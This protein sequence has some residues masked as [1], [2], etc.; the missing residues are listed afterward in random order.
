MN[1]PFSTF[2]Q[3]HA[4]IQQEMTEKFTQVYNRGW[5]IQGEEY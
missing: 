5:F 4:E 2:S 3:I 1:I